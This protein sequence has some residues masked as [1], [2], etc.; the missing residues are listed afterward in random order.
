MTL[1]TAFPTTSAAYPDL[2]DWDVDFDWELPA[3]RVK[4]LQLIV[5]QRHAPTEETFDALF[6]YCD[7]V[8]AD[9]DGMAATGE[10]SP[11]ADTIDAFRFMFAVLPMEVALAAGLNGDCY[12]WA[13]WSLVRNLDRR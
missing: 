1:R 9:L 13:N 6:G 7:A 11:R 3:G 5:A 2:L 4:A 8:A 12:G 10:I